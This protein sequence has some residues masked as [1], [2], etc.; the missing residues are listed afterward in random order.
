[1][2]E[3]VLLF[4]EDAAKIPMLNLEGQDDIPLPQKVCKILAF[5]AVITGLGLLFNI[6]LGFR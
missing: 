4:R 2:M 3:R 6:L 5:M 1:M